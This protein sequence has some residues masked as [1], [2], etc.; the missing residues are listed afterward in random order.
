MI[1]RPQSGGPRRLIALAGIVLFAA[2]IS[3]HLAIR[4]YWTVAA[5]GPE[6]PVEPRAYRNVLGD[7]EPRL[8]L[9]SREIPDLPY[10]VTT[11]A[12][13]FRGRRPAGP[14][15]SDNSLRVLCL[16]DSFTYGVGVDDG[17]TFP[18][19]L[20]AS[21]QTRFPDR[22]VEVINA[23]VPFYDLIDE[24]SYYRDKGRRLAPDVVVVQFYINDLEAMAGSFFRQDLLVRQGGVYN[25][26]DQMT[27]GEAVE[28][29]LNAWLD[30]RLPGLQQLWRPP[31]APPGPSSAGAGPFRAFHLAATPGEKKLLGDKTAL[32]DAR[33]LP[34]MERFWNNYRQVLLTLDNEVRHDGAALLLVLAPD[35]LQVREDLNAPAAALVPFC[36]ENAIPLIDMAR[37]LR[38]R[39]GGNPDRAFL[40]PRNGHP[41]LEGNTLMALAVADA[42]APAPG[43]DSGRLRLSPA[44]APFDYAN[45]SRLDVRLGPKGAVAAAS[46]PVAL[47]TVGRHNLAFSSLD[48]PGDNRIDIL[49]ADLAHGPTGELILR[50]DA[51]VPLDQVSVTLFRRLFP[52]ANGF[53]QFSWSRDG[54]SYTPL[55]FASDTDAAGPE[56][57]EVNRLM[58]LDLRGNPAGRLYFKLL[59]HNEAWIFTE[60]KAPPWRRFE[61]VCYPAAAGETP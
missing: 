29:R 12:H 26:F 43:A 56:G 25:A 49:H 47:T 9:V 35:V 52:P 54:V 10:T 24:L 16:G 13:G 53:V 19:L 22:T 23:G 4:A 27:G 21:L 39:S 34:A 33:N 59:L 28:R 58:E 57:F 31:A 38:A 11:N 8:A 30:S 48:M 41:N 17:Q 6:Q 14:A 7:L 5:A 61:I 3:T 2:V 15:R 50:L 60:S 18:A 32:L 45:P 46:G 37:V 1:S 42:F 40:V 20:E 36:R 51:A 44:E 55:L